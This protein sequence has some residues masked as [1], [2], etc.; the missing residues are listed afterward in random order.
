MTDKTATGK[1]KS[2]FTSA[3]ND[4]LNWVDERFPLTS[5]IKAHLTEY[6]APKN[7]NFWYFFGSLS[8]LVLVLQIVTGIF[9]TMH[10]KPDAALAFGSVEYIMRDVP[11]G[12]LIRY[13]H[14]TGA[15]MF[16]VAVYLHIFRG[17]YYGSYKEPRELLWMIGLVIFLTMKGEKYGLF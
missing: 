17:I 5:N 4:G 13:M 15:S 6:Y 1:N 7:F 10:Y 2:V 3:L 8:L 14:S 11:W 12:W 16:F 9:L